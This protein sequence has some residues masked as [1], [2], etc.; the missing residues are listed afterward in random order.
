PD[1]LSIA[2][3]LGGILVQVGAWKEAE[4]QAAKLLEKDPQNRDGLYIRASALLGQG[5]AAEAL[6][7]L[8]KIPPAETPPDLSRTAAAALFRLGKVS[9]AEQAIRA[10]RVADS[11]RLLAPVVE[12]APR[13][14]EARY[15]LSLAYLANNEPVPAIAQLEEL[16]RQVPDNTLTRF[17]LAV[18][19]SR[20]G[21]AR[22]ALAQ[23]DPLAK[24]LE[25]TADYHVERGHAL[26]L[27]G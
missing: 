22:E 7:L 20:A 9:E 21:R 26:L 12:R 17:R 3:D 23:L 8:E 24:T 16:Q 10:N 6:A 27:M 4:A 1:S 18:A 15:L 19:Y 2:T 14:A 13:F 5:K 11:I 25:K